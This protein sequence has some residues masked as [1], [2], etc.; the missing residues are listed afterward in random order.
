MANNENLGFE[1]RF[2]FQ[3]AGSA[4]TSNTA[5]CCELVSS[6]V[7]KRGTVWRGAGLTGTRDPLDSRT[8]KG[9][10][11]V[12]GDLVFDVSP[13]MF[14]YFFPYIFG[15]TEA[16][17]TFAVADAL[18]GFDFLHDPF[19]TGSAATKFG[20]LYVNRFRLEMRQSN[21]NGLLRMTLSVV[22]KT[23]TTGQTFNAAA[24][25][26]TAAVDTPYTFYDTNGGI[27]IRSGSGAQEV[28][29]ATLELNNNL[30]VKFRNSQTA[31]SIRAQ[32]R[33][34]AFDPTLP[35]TTTTL[36]NY[37]GDKTSAA[38]AIVIDNGTVVTTITLNN[39]QV[40]DEGP[41]VSGKG[42]V[43]L[44]LHGMASGDA[45]NKSILATV[46]GGSL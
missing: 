40:P 44:V 17:D 7:K 29:Q 26:S 42:E 37:F 27:T 33:E 36:S 39:L 43:P 14:D 16:T 34:V 13:R 24:L 5:F 3:P 32:D 18:P 30:D 25:G 46:V 38:A 45:S 31:T 9:I 12:G 8:R 28:E 15:A 2:A 4:F 11:S 21:D 20:E 35:L 19:G 23:I 1:N 41:E 6:S 22:G 10:I